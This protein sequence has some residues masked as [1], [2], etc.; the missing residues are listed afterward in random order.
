M[1][2]HSSWS[3]QP[4]DM[5]KPLI[6]FPLF[7]KISA[8]GE[9]FSYI[10]FDIRFVYQK[11]SN[12]WNARPPNTVN[13]GFFN[14]D[15]S[16]KFVPLVDME[17]SFVTAKFSP[18]CSKNVPC[19]KSRSFLPDFASFSFLQLRTK[20]TSFDISSCRSIR[21]TASLKQVSHFLDGFASEVLILALYRS[22]YDASSTDIV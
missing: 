20:I 14:C 13:S 21:F 8:V 18:S 3:Q 22:N 19:C 16:P 9:S 2:L 17:E 12:V 10:S 1:I 6:A 5:M 11:S 15:V 4:G 7:T